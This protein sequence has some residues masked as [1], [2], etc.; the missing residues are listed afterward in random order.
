[1]QYLQCVFY[2]LLSPKKA[3]GMC[4][5]ASKKSP[6]LKNYIV[7]GPPLLVL[8]FLEAPLKTEFVSP[9]KLG[10]KKAIGAKSDVYSQFYIEKFPITFTF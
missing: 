1:M 5:G 7:R 10:P 4:E 2:S 3:Y 6:D 8:K 9:L